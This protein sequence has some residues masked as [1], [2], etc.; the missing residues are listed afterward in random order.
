MET[1][2]SLDKSKYSDSE[3]DRKCARSWNSFYTVI[4][5]LFEG[6]EKPIG[7]KI[8]QGGITYIWE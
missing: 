3:V 8:E 7:Y 6:K 2:K 5:Q 4:D 1:A